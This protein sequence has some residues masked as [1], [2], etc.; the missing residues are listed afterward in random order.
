MKDDNEKQ[1]VVRLKA[2]DEGAFQQLVGAYHELLFRTL[3]TKIGEAEMARDLVQ[4]AFVKIWLKREI[5]RP[6]QSFFAIL[7]KFGINLAQDELRRR[8]VR[9]KHYDRVSELWKKP[10]ENPEASLVMSQTQ[11]LVSKVIAEDMPER[12]R[13]VFVLSRVEGLA[14]AEVAELLDISKKTVENQLNRAVK[15]LRKKCGSKLFVG[16]S[17]EWHG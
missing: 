11:A 12:C 10:G 3:V 13:Q 2:G 4:D 15:I 9:E 14:N 17:Q 6:D 8:K 7:A 1:L 16:A 5:L